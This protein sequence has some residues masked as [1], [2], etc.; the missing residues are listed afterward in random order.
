MDFVR[1]ITIAAENEDPPAIWTAV[2]QKEALYAIAVVLTQNI[3]VLCWFSRFNAFLNFNR[4]DIT[5]I[6]IN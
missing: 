2:E 4:I 6:D 3:E 1:K 5:G